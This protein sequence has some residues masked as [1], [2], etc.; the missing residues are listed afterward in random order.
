MYRRE[1]SIT[2]FTGTLRFI[3]L[4]YDKAYKRTKLKA[5]LFSLNRNAG[6]PRLDP[7]TRNIVIDRLQAGQ[8]QNEAA[9]KQS[10]TG[11]DSMAFDPEGHISERY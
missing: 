2:F 10:A 11:F 9:R 7:A 5:W 4:L 6:M 8:S 1:N 3:Q